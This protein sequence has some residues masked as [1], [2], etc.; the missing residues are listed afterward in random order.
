LT[1]VSKSFDGTT[2][3]KRLNLEVFRGETL[4]LLGENGAGKSTLKNILCGL[5]PSDGGEIEFDG[6]VQE[7]WSSARAKE[8]GLA[9]IHQELSLFSNMTVAENVHMLSLGRG[10]SGL[11]SKKQLVA[12]TNQLFRD[13]LEIEMDSSK[14]VSDLALGQRQLVEIVKAIQSAS[15]VLVLDEP[16]TSLSISERRQLF[17]VMRRLRASGHALI[18]VTHF[19]EEVEEVGDRVAVMRDGEVVALRHKDDLTIPQIEQFMVGRELAMVHRER[20]TVTEDSPVL[21]EATDLRDDVILNGVSLSVRA[22]EV[23]GIAGLNGAGRSELM[24]ALVGLRPSSGTVQLKGE[25]YENRSVKESRRRGMVL[26]SEDR[27]AEQ[28]FLERTVR[29]NLSSSSLDRV[30]NRVGVMRSRKEKA[31]SATLVKEFGVKTASTEADFG[32]MSGGNQQKAVLARW[33][34]LEP[35]VCLLD[36]PTK[37]IDVGAKAEVQR[38]I[39]GL[40]EQGV[41]VVVVSSDLPEL[42]QVSDRILVMRGGGIAAELPRDE[43]DPATIL[44][45]ASSGRD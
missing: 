41:A 21:L 36:E 25:R 27:R 1:G 13:L 6:V 15:N 37:G 23:L 24:Q 28:A 32:A 26:V 10:R 39:F 45:A 33:L 19:L 38:T 40:A 14:L 31:M 2:V 11:V 35:R 42:F 3:L 20:I 43:F 4:I 34:G 18:H 22:G 16:T 29:E 9:A 12:R 44:R 7:H 17:Q 5:I 8:V 30:S